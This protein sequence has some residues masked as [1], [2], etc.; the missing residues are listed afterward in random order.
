MYLVAEAVFRRFFL[1]L[2]PSSRRLPSR[3]PCTA[4]RFPPL[5]G[6]R[7]PLATRHAGPPR[8]PQPP[9]SL[10]LQAGHHAASWR[11][12]NFTRLDQPE[13]HLRDLTGSPSPRLSS[14]PIIMLP[15]Y[16]SV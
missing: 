11:I 3:S 9:S 4:R 8:R 2:F 14:K 1:S 15:V 13:E 5:A 10:Q 12:L 6:R 7:S 16:I